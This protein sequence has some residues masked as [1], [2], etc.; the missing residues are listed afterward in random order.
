[1]KSYL[2]SLSEAETVPTQLLFFNRGAFLTNQAANTLADL[3][4]LAEKGNHDSNVWGLFRFLSFNR[5]LSY[6]LYY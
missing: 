2:Q 3:Q 6:R 5:H 4:Q 1:M